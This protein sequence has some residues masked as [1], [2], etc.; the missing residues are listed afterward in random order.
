[1]ARIFTIYLFFYVYLNASQININDINHVLSKEQTK[2]LTQIIQKEVSFHKKHMRLP[3]SI[4]YNLR[5]CK[6]NRSKTCQQYPSLRSNMF[7]GLYVYKKHEAIIKQSNSMF[8]TIIHESN[9]MLIHVGKSTHIPSWINEGLSEY[10][11]T[12][13]M[14]NGT[15]FATI[16]RQSLHKLKK[17]HRNDQLPPMASI[18]AWKRNYWKSVDQDRNRD[19]KSRTISWGLVYFLM[20][21]NH[22]KNLLHTIIKV[23]RKKKHENIVMIIQKHYHGGFSAFQKDF[24]TFLD[25]MPSKQK[26]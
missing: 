17:W 21:S 3:P 18:L 1:M 26:L 15:L 23:L 5:I 6:N 24:Y 16:Q 9:H 25:H 19:Y 4:T 11:E 2:L 7:V 8:L 10:Y 20:S 14:I 12:A 13:T 22:G